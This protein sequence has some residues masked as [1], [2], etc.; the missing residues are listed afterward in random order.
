MLSPSLI[1]AAI[2]PP[3]VTKPPPRSAP[4]VAETSR[5]RLSP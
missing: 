2:D 3:T 4:S 5:L 1:S